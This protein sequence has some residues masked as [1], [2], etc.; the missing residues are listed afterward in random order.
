[1][2]L[3]EEEI[4]EHWEEIAKPKIDLFL[5]EFASEEDVDWGKKEEPIKLISD[6]FLFSAWKTQKTIEFFLMIKRKKW[7]MIWLNAILF[8]NRMKIFTR[9]K[10]DREKF[11]QK[12]Q[13]S[14]D[15]NF[16]LSHSG[17]SGSSILN[18]FVKSRYDARVKKSKT[19]HEIWKD[20]DLMRKCIDWQLMNET[21]RHSAKRFMNAMAFSTGFRLVSNIG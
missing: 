21:G 19:I 18:H 11:F 12:I 8:K 1:M 16:F 14:R 10:K 2:I 7:W 9:S 13:E 20:L 15:K 4:S 5:K 17:T 6:L 3:W